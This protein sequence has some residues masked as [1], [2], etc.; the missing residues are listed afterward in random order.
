MS[1]FIKFTE[2]LKKHNP[3]LIEAIQS[4]YRAL[5]E[6]DINNR[7]IVIVDIQPSYEDGFGFNVYE[8]TEYLNEHYQDMGRILY[9]YNGEDLGMESSQDIIYW[10]LENGLDEDVISSLDFFE[11]NYAFFRNA[12]DHGIDHS[13][14]VKLLKY[15]TKVDIN[16]SR[17]LDELT[18]KV[19]KSNNEDEDEIIEFLQ[20]N[21]DMI[22]LPEL[23][24]KLEIVTNPIVMGGGRDECLAEVLIAMQ[25]LDISYSTFN[26]FIY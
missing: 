16:D 13:S 9:L 26:Q 18:W 10:L 6:S 12:M 20:D 17:D 2:R 3:M 24:E 21:D 19:F 1:K 14:I 22:N 5:H 25:V 7:D 8:F 15:M 4:G 11:K 23:M